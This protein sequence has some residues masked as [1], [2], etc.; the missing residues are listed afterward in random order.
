MNKILTITNGI[1]TLDVE[2][3]STIHT[4]VSEECMIQLAQV[5]KINPK[6]IV[7]NI[8][9]NDMAIPENDRMN[10]YFV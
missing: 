10:W 4:K 3:T 9:L 8:L 1:D 7:L 2:C 5:D 6:S